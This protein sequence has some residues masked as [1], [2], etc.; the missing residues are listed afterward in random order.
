MRR[1]LADHLLA[2]LSDGST[3]LLLAVE[4]NMAP[5]AESGTE[6]MDTG[7]ALNDL[8]EKYNAYRPFG[9]N[10][11]KG[12]WVDP[13]ALVALAKIYRVDFAILYPDA[14][15]TVIRERD[16]HPAPNCAR[17]ALLQTPARPAS[18]RGRESGEGRSPRLNH[19]A[20]EE[21]NNGSGHFMALRLLGSDE[22]PNR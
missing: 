22:E 4:A 16:G 18:R 8:T 3:E 20:S 19:T 6:S 14:S 13:Y 9:V 21:L 1:Q 5:D 7:G 2:S 12:A 11:G 15:W 17:I 10:G